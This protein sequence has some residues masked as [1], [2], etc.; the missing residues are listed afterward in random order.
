MKNRTIDPWPIAI[1]SSAYA[2]TISS[3]AGT[4]VYS[5]SV[6]SVVPNNGIVTYGAIY[7]LSGSKAPGVGTLIGP[8]GTDISS[9][10]TNLTVTE[11]SD[12]DPGWLRA[13]EVEDMSASE[14]GV[15]TC[16]MPDEKGEMVE[17]NV[18]LYPTN[19]SK[20]FKGKRI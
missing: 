14:G 4:G 7:C 18:G 11:G 10:L 1:P 17:M 2:C 19:T 16:R 9:S 5:E 15:Y 12:E 8:Q 20:K 6:D 13:G 3:F